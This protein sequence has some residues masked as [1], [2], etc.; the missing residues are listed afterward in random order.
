HRRSIRAWRICAPSSSAAC[1]TGRENVRLL[2]MTTMLA[3]I[4]H[5]KTEISGA[6]DAHRRVSPFVRY[7]RLS[8]PFALLPDGS[9]EASIGLERAPRFRRGARLGSDAGDRG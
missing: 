1:W 2:G 7:L 4:S 3:D 9:P 5:V 8:A 6:R